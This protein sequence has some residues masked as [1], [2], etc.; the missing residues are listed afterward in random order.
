MIEFT[1]LLNFV[2]CNLK[3]N[4]KEN[5]YIILLRLIQKIY[6]MKKAKQD[7]DDEDE[8]YNDVYGSY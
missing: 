2:E 6:L 4:I 7:S 1:E 3:N 5:D 8:D